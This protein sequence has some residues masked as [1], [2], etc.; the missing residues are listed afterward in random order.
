MR[1]RHV[2]ELDVGLPAVRTQPVRWTRSR[3]ADIRAR[4][5]TSLRRSRSASRSHTASTTCSPGVRSQIAIK[6]YGDDLDTLRGRPMPGAP[7]GRH[8]RPRGPGNREAGAGAADQGA[9]RLRRSGCY[10]V[11]APAD[12]AALQTWSRAKVTQMV[13]GGR[14]LRWSCAARIGALGRGGLA[15]IAD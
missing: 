5:R 6:I 15:Q 8:P 7:A 2:S 12:L 10:G 11:P 13:E 1:R 3:Q 14:A 9:R 4:L